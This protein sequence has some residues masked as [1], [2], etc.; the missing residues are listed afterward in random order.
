M[1]KRNRLLP[2][3]PILALVAFLLLAASL[4]GGCRKTERRNLGSGAPARPVAVVNNER[5]TLEEFFDTYQLFLTRWDRFIQKD[6]E[7]KE[8]LKEIVL[9][10]MIDEKLMDQEVRRRGLELEDAEV[11]AEIHRL[12]GPYAR[13]D[14]T[15]SAS[16]SHRTLQQWRVEFRRRM[17]HENLIV[18]EVVARIRVTQREMRAY[19]ERNRKQFET[20]EQVRVRHIAV[21]SRSDYRKLVRALRRDADFVEL[22][23][24]YSVTP[25]RARDGDLGFVERGV[26]PPEFDQVIFKLTRVGSINP[27]NKPVKTQIG[28]HLFRLEGRKPSANLTFKEAMPLIR[29]ILTERKQPVAFQTWIQGLRDRA[30][31]RINRQL[32]AAG[33]G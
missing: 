30:T 16:M 33:M 2:Q 29:K 13:D 4:P 20:Q 22:V 8:E 15:R 10:N 5:I 25:D 18:R 6:P 23:R 1:R 3:V 31:I 9:A 28:Y 17:L 21:G 24:K 14:L 26:L 12:T 19:Y 7:K 11:D 27:T 32:L